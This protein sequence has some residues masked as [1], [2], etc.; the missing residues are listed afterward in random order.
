[1]LARSLFVLPQVPIESWLVLHQ[2]PTLNNRF[3][4]KQARIVR[5]ESGYFVMLTLKCDVNV[6]DA[7]SSGHALG[8]LETWRVFC[9]G[10]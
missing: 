4:I 2:C 7:V 5:K 9:Q 8:V 3:V 6:P 1:M 10:Q